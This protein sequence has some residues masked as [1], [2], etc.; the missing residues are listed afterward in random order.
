MICATFLH[1]VLADHFNPFKPEI[2][3]VNFI[4]YKPRIAT[5]PQFDVV[6]EDDF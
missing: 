4:H 5:R 1:D 3:I 2:D 6:D